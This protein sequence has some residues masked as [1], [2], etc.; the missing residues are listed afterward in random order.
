MTNQLMDLQ[1]GGAV[2]YKR[3]VKS[4]R[5]GAGQQ[6]IGGEKEGGRELLA[7]GVVRKEGGKWLSISEWELRI[8]NLICRVL[9]TEEPSAFNITKLLLPSIRKT[10]TLSIKD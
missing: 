7:Q 1:E 6:A 4:Y 2:N 8:N 9:C 3:A 5:R 10:R